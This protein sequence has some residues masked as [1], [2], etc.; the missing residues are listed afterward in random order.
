MSSWLIILILASLLVISVG[1]LLFL[2]WN[3]RRMTNQLENIIENFGTN[4]LIRTNTHSKSLL[5]FLSKINQLIRMFK[6]DQQQAQKREKELKQEI[7][8]ISHDLRTPLTSIKGFS[9][10]LTDPAL[11]ETEKKEFLEIIQKKI[12]NLTMTVDLFYEMSQIDSADLPLHIEQVLLDQAVVDT[13]LMFYSDFE[14]R[15]LKIEMEEEVVPPVLADKKAADRIINNIIQ[16]ALHYAESYFSIQLTEDGEYVQLKAV[17]DISG[18]DQGDLD[19]IFDRS[20]R[21]DRSRTGD[22][23]GLGLHIV[24]KLIDRQGGKVAA[25]LQGNEFQVKVWFKK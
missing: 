10:L 16:N 8:N 1:I 7:T 6:Q 3:V 24:Q 2:H 12:D 11:S 23:L 21:I 5:L 25:A 9:E 20:F 17:N 13:M 18:F 4:E 19:R 15:Q 14:K 22:H